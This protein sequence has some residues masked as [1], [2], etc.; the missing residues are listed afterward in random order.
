M[1]FHRRF[2]YFRF[3]MGQSILLARMISIVLVLAA[4]FDSVHGAN[5][6]STPIIKDAMHVYTK[7]FTQLPSFEGSTAQIISMV[8]FKQDL[9]VCTLKRIYR[10]KQ[11]G[12][13]S[14]FMDVAKAFLEETGRPLN[15]ANAQHG[16]VR[17]IAFHP[18]FDS[19]QL[20]YISAMEQR[21]SNPSAFRYISDVSDPI[22][23]DSVLVEFRVDRTS[24]LPIQNTYRLLFRVGMPVYDHPIK[25]MVF[26]DNYL[27]ISHGDGSAQS[28]VVGGGQGD[29]ALGKILRIYPRQFGPYPYL[30]PASN[31]FLYNRNMK[32]EVFALGFRNPHHLCFD[33]K[34]RLFVAD[35]G[36]DNVEE[37]NI[38]EAGRNYGWPKREG[39][40]VHLPDGGLLNGVAP[41]PAND[42]EYGFVY[43]VA[44]VGHD[45]PVGSFFIGQAIAG[46]CPIENGS[47][48][49]GHYFY[50][51][52]P[53]SGNLYFSSLAEMYG[54]KTTGDPSKLT[55]ARTK[56]AV[57]FFDHDDDPSTPPLKLN[58]LGDVL[59]SESAF[60]SKSRVDVRLGRGPN[61]EMYW[62]SKQNGR[63]Y[64]FT[65]SLPGGPG[66]LVKD[67]LSKD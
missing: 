41:L 5:P 30:I 34:G 56:Q 39:T 12:S 67:N 54:A 11:D 55:Q 9:Y 4:C 48:M 38:V 49:S 33:S 57:I 63:I 58:S 51:D 19:N 32:S 52:F 40:F 24:E 26:R 22:E 3:R 53:E 2:E 64:L 44:Q 45:G 31:P 27:Y 37:I 29:D 35:T 23:A 62:S 7:N 1:M 10:V 66:G 18:A 36:R 42:S 15:V 16:G 17:S 20:F 61:G 46:G 13:H 43:P 50:S 25:Q 6:I 47:P 28:A 14:L 65:S 8:P 60:A 59:R 21:P